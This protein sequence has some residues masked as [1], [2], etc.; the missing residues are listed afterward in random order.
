MKQTKREYVHEGQVPNTLDLFLEWVNEL[1]KTIPV[2]LCEVDFDLEEDWNSDRLGIVAFL[3]SR[4]TMEIFGAT[5]G[6]VALTYG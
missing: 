5:R 4:E 3:Q 1:A 6:F 2:P